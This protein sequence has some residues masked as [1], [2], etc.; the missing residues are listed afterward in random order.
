MEILESRSFDNNKITIICHN[1][2][3][4]KKGKFYIISIP[5][6]LS[7]V[8]SD[9]LNLDNDF[10]KTNG[11]KDSK[12]LMDFFP[13]A[14]YGENFVKE[15]QLPEFLK[16]VTNIDKHFD[17]NS[18][19]SIKQE[20]MNLEKIIFNELQLFLNYHHFHHRKISLGQKIADIFAQPLDSVRFLIKD[21]FILKE[22]KRSFNMY[23]KR[24]V[25]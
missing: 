25:K 12:I 6:I 9:V 1:E 23:E 3:Q 10:L 19:F 5:T 11:H 13:I 20:V 24:E 22:M 16:K 21:Y 8:Y 17:E 4:F 18:D 2:T 7:K 15:S 14:V